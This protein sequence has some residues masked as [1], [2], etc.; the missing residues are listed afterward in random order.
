MNTNTNTN[1]NTI[2]TTV[3]D[4]TVNDTITI[5]PGNI[6]SNDTTA[7]LGMF[8][9]R[10]E[11]IPDPHNQRR[12]IDAAFIK[13]IAEH[14]VLEPIL[15]SP[16]T[17]PARPDIR[18][19]I[20]AGERRYEASGKAG[21]GTIPAIIRNY[22]DAER[23][24]IQAVENLH[25]AGITIT[26]EALQAARAV[27]IGLTRKDLATKFGKSTKWLASRLRV[28]DTPKTLWSYID[29]ER[30]PLDTLPLVIELADDKTAI[31]E[32][33][34]ILDDPDLWSEDISRGLETLCRER[35]QNAAVAEVT[36]A[37]IDDGKTII[38]WQGEYPP[39]TAGY[40]TLNTLGL[41][42]NKKH[43][44]ET[45]AAIAIKVDRHTGIVTAVE[46]CTDP[47][48]HAAKGDSAH[49]TPEANNA[50]NSAASPDKTADK[51]LARRLKETHAD[52]DGFALAR[53]P[54][55]KQPEMVA[56]LATFVTELIDNDTAK[57]VAQ[58]L[59]IPPVQTTWGSPDWTA[60]IAKY[61]VDNPTN[62]TLIIVA[63]LAA[64]ARATSLR[65]PH[66]T[67]TQVAAYMT[68]RGWEPLHP[69]DTLA[70]YIPKPTE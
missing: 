23:I 54:D 2:D 26:Q 24:V 39:V 18:Y 52:R 49:K 46:V 13:T 35:R 55:M 57:K 62:K 66:K 19:M 12:P 69:E 16:Y 70:A 11:I 50:A 60:T 28:L 27:D 59:Y 21:H 25:R 9:D 44:N 3:N 14:G 4:T 40:Q 65:P 8:V 32:L 10:T 42:T 61:L 22:S 41:T 15:L 43:L 37:A 48:R 7:S 38:E 6:A 36:K 1:T 20:V 33:K 5:G 30:L 34:A 68:A 45:C 47:K 56:F 31:N 64:Y 53:V 29:N 17:D 58:I 63:S 51:E 67:A